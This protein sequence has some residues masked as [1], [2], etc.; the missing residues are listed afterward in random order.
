MSRQFG[1]KGRLAHFFFGQKNLRM[2]T[3]FADSYYLDIQ[4]SFCK[5]ECLKLT[6]QSR[7]LYDRGRDRRFA[8]DVPVNFVVE[9]PD[10]LSIPLGLE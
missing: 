8:P 2:S 5:A 3:R 4:D 9:Q 6:Y 10:D 7:K 1:K